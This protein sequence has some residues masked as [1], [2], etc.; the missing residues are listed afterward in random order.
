M[1]ENKFKSTTSLD[2][3]LC[4]CFVKFLLF[5]HEQKSAFGL[6]NLLIAFC[7]IAFPEGDKNLSFESPTLTLELNVSI[8]K[9]F[10]FFFSIILPVTN[11]SAVTSSA[12]CNDII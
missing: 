7:R 2:Y 4:S 11:K 1:I 10:L 9:Y 6:Q 3:Y 5:D 12:T 8:C